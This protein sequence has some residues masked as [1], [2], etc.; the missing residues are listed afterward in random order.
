MTHEYPL[1]DA[2]A[3]LSS[4]VRQVREGATVVITVHGERVAELR[5]YVAPQA[6]NGLE[7]RMAE[8]AARGALI[9]P[10]LTAGESHSLRLGDRDP[11]VV[12]R[13]LDER[14]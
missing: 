11:G 13:F 6:E 9:P 4:L 7:Q 10:R 8:L 2:K 12:Q 14:E 1:Y 5:P 3:R